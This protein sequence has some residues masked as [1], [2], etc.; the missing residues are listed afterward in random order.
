MSLVTFNQ[1]MWKIYYVYFDIFFSYFTIIIKESLV[2]PFQ[3]KTG[4]NQKTQKRA[5]GVFL[6]FAW[7]DPPGPLLSSLHSRP[8]PVINALKSPGRSCN[9]QV[10]GLMI[11]MLRQVEEL[12]WQWVI[13]G[14]CEPSLEDLKALMVNSSKNTH[15]LGGCLDLKQIQWY[16][17]RVGLPQLLQG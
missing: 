17:H 5:S 10:E 1:F 15:G 11:P 8:H 6:T 13:Y 3:S 7:A 16:N 4:E 9:S 12:L 14:L 2:F